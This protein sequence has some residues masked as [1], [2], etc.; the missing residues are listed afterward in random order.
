MNKAIEIRKLGEL[1]VI[2]TSAPYA[3][4]PTRLFHTLC[5]DKTDSLLL[6]SAE[7]DSK[8]NLKSLLIVDSAVRIVCYGHEVTMTALTENGQH[9]LA[10][11][12]QIFTHK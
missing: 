8:Q 1:E 10:H 11:L 5:A 2:H 9:L 7:I 6:E 4:D 12:N 3:Q